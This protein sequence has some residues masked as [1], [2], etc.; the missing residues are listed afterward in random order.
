MRFLRRHKAVIVAALIPQLVLGTVLSVERLVQPPAAEAV[1]FESVQA[2]KEWGLDMVAKIII[3]SITVSFYNSFLTWVRSGFQGPPLFVKEP[4]KYFVDEPSARAAELTKL[5]LAAS[6]LCPPFGT[7]R[8]RSISDPTGT[9]RR[10]PDLKCNIPN[11][12]AAIPKFFRNFQEGSWDMWNLMLLP[13]NNAFGQFALIMDQSAIERG[14]QITQASDIY[15]AGQGSPGI[16]GCSVQKVEQIPRS[17]GQALQ[18]FSTCLNHL[19]LTPGRIVADKVAEALKN[20]VIQNRF[21]DEITEL[22]AAA[23]NSLLNRLLKTNFQ[24]LTCGSS[25][26]TGVTTIGFGERGVDYCIAAGCQPGRFICSETP[27][28]C[29]QSAA[30]CTTRCRGA[31][32]GDPDAICIQCRA[33]RDGDSAPRQC[34]AGGGSCAQGSWYCTVAGQENICAGDS[35]GCVAVPPSGSGCRGPCERCP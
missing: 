33:S 6:G 30:D 10:I 31:N 9:I 8:G 14:K 24:C 32:P 27:E 35:G 20:D 25:S 16:Q 29:T 3:N 5:Q 4:R 19:N 23:I 21:I 7:G 34:T 13:N 28:I 2:A 17:A 15:K 22:I 26:T 12:I 1:V 11:A 18:A